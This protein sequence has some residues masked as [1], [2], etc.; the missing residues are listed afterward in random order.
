[1]VFGL[2]TSPSEE[3]RRYVLVRL[4]SDH[5]AHERGGSIDDEMDRFC[6]FSQAIIVVHGFDGH[7]Q[8]KVDAKSH[9]G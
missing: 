2:R 3:E 7:G 8:S 1:M 9:V 4:L 6:G 5:I